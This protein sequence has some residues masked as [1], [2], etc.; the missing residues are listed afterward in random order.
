MQ[1]NTKPRSNGKKIKWAIGLLLVVGLSVTA[2]WYVFLRGTVYSDDARID[3]ELVDLAPEL[4]GTL[5]FVLADEGDRVK[6]G[7]PL[8]ALDNAILEA[9]QVQAKAEV[10]SAKAGLSIA[11]AE[12]Q[13]AVNGPR[14]GEIRVAQQAMEQAAAQARLAE[15]TWQRTKELLDSGALPQAELDRVKA[16]LETIDHQRQAAKERLDLLRRGTRIEDKDAALGAV[17]A[18]KARVAVAEAVLNQANI[19][20]EKAEVDAPFDGVVVRRWRDPG[21]MLGPGTPVLTLMNPATLYVAANIE[22]KYLADVAVGDRVTIEIDAYPDESFSG[23]ITQVLRSTNSTFSL[24]PSE[25]V[26]G[27]FI[28]V[29]Q[30]VPLK[31]AFD[32]PPGHALG[33]GLSVEVRIYSGVQD[34][35]VSATATQE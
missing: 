23:H 29:T 22:E 28:K 3:G 21:A 32:A 30:R 15:T 18:A 9:A 31:I 19:K 14:G 2:Y 1:D 27:T 17:E 13:K 20:L 10:V 7:Q 8:F 16:N 11:E 26:S 34:K 6:K 33:P 24:I 35:T 5:K 4:G 25:G 12:H